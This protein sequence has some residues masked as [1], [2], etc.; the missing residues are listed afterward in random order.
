MHIS[1]CCKANRLFV[2]RKSHFSLLNSKAL[3]N[4][5]TNGHPW[6]VFAEYSH[7]LFQMLTLIEL[8]RSYADL[9]KGENKIDEQMKTNYTF[10]RQMKNHF[11]SLSQKV[12]AA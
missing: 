7:R 12:F 9:T 2:V 6:I 1:I 10:H 4:A 8:F 5:S 11:C 3:A